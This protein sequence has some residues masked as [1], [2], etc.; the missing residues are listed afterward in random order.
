MENNI[1][2]KGKLGVME[3]V[4]GTVDQPIIDWCIIEE[5][6]THQQNLAV[7]YQNYSKVYDKVNHD[8]LL[9]LYKRMGTAQAVV[10]LLKELKSRRKTKLEILKRDKSVKADR[11]LL[12][13][14]RGWEQGSM[15]NT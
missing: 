10:S 5:V 7:A 6:I 11:N 15:Q 3:G 2:D 1:W 13:N 9:C 14:G 4:L 12:V 8:W